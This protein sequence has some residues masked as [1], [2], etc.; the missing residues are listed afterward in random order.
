MWASDRVDIK[1]LVLIRK[2]FRA[3]YGKDFEQNAINN[4]GGVLNERV[5]SKLSVQP[6]AAYLVQAYLERICEQHE[7]SWS[8]KVPVEASGMAEPMAAPVGYSVQVAGGTGLGAASTAAQMHINTYG[9]RGGGGDEIDKSQPPTPVVNAT[10]Y[11]P[12]PA[13]GAQED[14][15]EVDIFVPPPPM[16]PVTAM[17]SPKDNDEN[18]NGDEGAVNGDGGTKTMGASYDDLAARFD[19]LKK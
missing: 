8:P 17:P 16:A 19:Q 5:V 18:D 2:Q 13:P 10:P 15:A 3:K 14:F 12:P 7:V 4:V 6:P 9:G 1:E 11:I